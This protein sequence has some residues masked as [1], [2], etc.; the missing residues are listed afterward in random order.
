MI[1]CFAGLIIL[2]SSVCHCSM[3]TFRNAGGSL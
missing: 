3:T 1:N 2:N